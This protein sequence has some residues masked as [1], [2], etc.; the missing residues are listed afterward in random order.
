ML[1]NEPQEW[2]TPVSTIGTGRGL[3]MSLPRL[4]CEAQD[5]ALYRIGHDRIPRFPN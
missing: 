4:T 2:H 5:F 1:V 3:F